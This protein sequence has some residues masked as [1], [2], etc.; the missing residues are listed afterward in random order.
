MFA[1]ECHHCQKRYLVGT[2]AILSF[3]NTDHGPEAVV[4]CPRGH[5]VLHDF[6][7]DASVP[8]AAEVALVA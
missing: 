3:R 7:T 8:V 5:R 1:I 2:S 4:G 6:H